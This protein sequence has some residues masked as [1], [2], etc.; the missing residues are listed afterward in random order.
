D[1]ADPGAGFREKGEPFGRVNIGP[2]LGD[3]A[4]GASAS[5]RRL[6]P[7]SA[8]ADGTVDASACDSEGFRNARGSTVGTEIECTLGARSLTAFEIEGRPRSAVAAG[9]FSDGS[10]KAARFFGP[11]D[12]GGVS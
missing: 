4:D 1:F 10:G 6:S 3:A 12:G 5:L 2:F 11:G 7:S 9:C 8:S